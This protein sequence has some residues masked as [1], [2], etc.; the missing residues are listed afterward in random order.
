MNGWIMLGIWVSNRFLETI[1]EIFVH[2]AYYR[3]QI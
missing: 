2:A 1:R 3:A